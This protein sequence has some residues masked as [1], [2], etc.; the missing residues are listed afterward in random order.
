[1]RIK[2]NSLSLH[3]NSKGNLLKLEYFHDDKL[4]FAKGG[5]MHLRDYP[6]GEWG[7][8]PVTEVICYKLA[9]LMGLSAAK[10]ELIKVTG[11][12]YGHEIRNIMCTSPDFRDGREMIYLN[13]LYIENERFLNF[14]YLCR[15]TDGTELM[16][17]LAFDL[18]IMNE[19]RHNGNI[20]W[21]INE[22]GELRMTPFFDN[23][24]SLLYDD[25][26]GMLKDFKA[27]SKHCICN[28][29]LYQDSFL[30]AERLFV[31]YSKIYR[32]SATLD[33]SES[34]IAGMI[35][36][37]YDEYSALWRDTVK[38][39]KIP[40]EWWDRVKE[41][42]IWRLEYVRNLRDCGEE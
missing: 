27:A 9:G 16:N 3:S 2:P 15:K 18:T 10:Q 33:I 36:I 42:I 41:F 13:N 8:E 5:R 28:S 24:Y 20:A 40:D 38:N 23:G 14:D 25:I 22:L 29:P 4:Y 6:G 17:L 1:M 12:R 39:F 19:D 34:E 7:M 11:K 26:K 37:V 31:K 21:F 35:E 32:P 30:S